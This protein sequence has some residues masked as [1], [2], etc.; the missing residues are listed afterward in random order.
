MLNV[1]VTHLVSS[2]EFTLLSL[3]SESNVLMGIVQ[4]LQEFL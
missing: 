3:H 1:Q 4:V 2:P